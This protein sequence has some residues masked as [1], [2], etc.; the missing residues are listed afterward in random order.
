M[1]LSAEANKLYILG[2]A[3]EEALNEDKFEELFALLSERDRIIEEM[4][5]SQRS[6]TSEES[7]Q[8]QSQN[9][10]LG[11][12]LRAAQAHLAETARIGQQAVRA[13]RAYRS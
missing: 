11:R 4:T 9:E 8:L 13:A 7:R 5:S 6:L 10:H 1:P 2:L 12:R 3:V